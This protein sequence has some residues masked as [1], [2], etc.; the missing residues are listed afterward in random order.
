MTFAPSAFGFWLCVI[1]SWGG[2]G[3]GDARLLF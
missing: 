3:F 1:A 2:N